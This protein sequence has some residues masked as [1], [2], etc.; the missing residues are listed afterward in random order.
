[1]ARLALGAC[2]LAALTACDDAGSPTS[3]SLAPAATPMAAA[4]CVRMLKPIHLPS[5]GVSARRVCL[6]D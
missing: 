6:I 5:V 4:R 3:P 2:L 1:M